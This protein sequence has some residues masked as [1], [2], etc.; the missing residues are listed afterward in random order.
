MNVW[1]INPF[2]YIPNWPTGFSTMLCV[3]T[4]CGD[5]LYITYFN[6]SSIHWLGLAHVSWE[7]GGMKWWIWSQGVSTWW[8][9]FLCGAVYTRSHCPWDT[10]TD[11]AVAVFSKGG[12]AVLKGLR[13]NE[14]V[15]FVVVVWVSVKRDFTHL[16]K[17]TEMI[18]M[19][20]WTYDFTHISPLK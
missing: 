9:S 17:G 16:T 7:G 15:V 19:C 3:C 10:G 8:S 6:V 14:V 5:G 12:G 11:M 13:L 18:C 1:V 20:S 2:K 4:G